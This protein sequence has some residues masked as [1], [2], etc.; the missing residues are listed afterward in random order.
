[1]KDVPGWVPGTYY[2]TPVYYRKGIWAEPSLQE[3]YAH[4][5][6]RKGFLANFEERHNH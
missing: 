4:A 6:Y 2:G 1:M 5:D 3:Y